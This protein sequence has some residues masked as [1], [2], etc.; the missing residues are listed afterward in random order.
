MALLS[1]EGGKRLRVRFPEI[2]AVLGSGSAFRIVPIDIA[3][4]S[5]V[6]DLGDGL[7]D[8]GDRTIYATARVHRLRLVT[9]D[10]RR[11]ESNLV[12]VVE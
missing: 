12:S 5:E 4:A 10:R 2:F 1:G 8:P 3:V 9:S 6:V 7:R 11:I